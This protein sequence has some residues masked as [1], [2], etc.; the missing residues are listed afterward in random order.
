MLYG[1]RRAKKLASD[2]RTGTRM[3]GGELHQR[4]EEYLAGRRTRSASTQ[5]V[6]SDYLASK[7]IPG[8][9]YF[10][11]M[12]REGKRGTRNLVIFDE[13]LLNRIKVLERN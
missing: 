10:D 6:V 13:N 11:Q 3:T 7:G 1:S 8:I 9:K 12:S 4:L 2:P 5:K